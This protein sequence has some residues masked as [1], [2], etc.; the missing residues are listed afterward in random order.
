VSSVR[1]LVV[2]DFIPFRQ[3]IASILG[4]VRE[5]EIICEVSDGLEAVRKAVALKP[6]LVLLDIGLPTL[7]GIEAA[8]QIRRLAPE[9][10]IIFVTQESSDDV[11]EEAL[12]LGAWGYVVKSRAAIDLLAA[13]EAVIIDQ[14]FVGGA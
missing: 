11:V 2:E 1:V 3:V 6:D 7:N 9:S 10:K 8:R 5:L 4:N 12:S 13:V 14:Q